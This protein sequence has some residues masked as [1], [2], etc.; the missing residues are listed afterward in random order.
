M[1]MPPTNLYYGWEYLRGG[2]NDSTPVDSDRDHHMCR[3]WVPTAFRLAGD[4]SVVPRRK[5]FTLI[6]MTVSPMALHQATLCIARLV[7]ICCAVL[8]FSSGVPHRT[9]SRTHHACRERLGPT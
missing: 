9:G 7:T 5:Y 6:Y 2:Y 8:I 4:P 1:L 3:W